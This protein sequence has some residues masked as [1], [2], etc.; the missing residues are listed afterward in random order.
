MTPTFEQLVG[1]YVLVVQS[2]QGEESVSR[3]IRFTDQ[4]A[5][6]AEFL[7]EQVNDELEA[8]NEGAFVSLELA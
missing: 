2:A 1:E 4:Q 7:L 5:Q 6:F 3:T 8:A